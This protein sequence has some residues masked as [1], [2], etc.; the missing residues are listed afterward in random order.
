MVLPVPEQ[1]GLRKTR[2][3][4]NEAKSLAALEEVLDLIALPRVQLA[5]E[6]GSRHVRR[7][8]ESNRDSAKNSA[9]GVWPVA[10]KMH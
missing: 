2:D 5:N 6:T 4:G 9:A 1:S 7:V 3:L 10:P 8:T